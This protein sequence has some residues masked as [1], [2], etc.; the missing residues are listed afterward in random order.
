MAA[1]I[2]TIKEDDAAA[3]LGLLQRLDVETA[4]MLMDPGERTAS[5]DELRQRIR[6]TLGSENQTVLVAD[7]DRK[8]VGFIGATGGPYRRNRHSVYLAMGVLESHWGQGLGRSLLKEV[9]RWALARRLRRLEL[10][11]MVH[12]ERALR[13]YRGAGFRF[14]GTKREALVVDGRAIDEHMMAKLLG[15]APSIPEVRTP[16]A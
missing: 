8:L 12:N 2:R 1:S 16:D 4:F 3:F 13:L 11:V 6:A 7:V 5:V 9:E 10:T 14:E 15:D